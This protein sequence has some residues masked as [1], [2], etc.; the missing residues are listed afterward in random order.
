MHV[1]NI[2]TSNEKL[3]DISI[4]CL[5]AT[6]ILTLIRRYRN[7]KSHRRRPPSSHEL[8]IGDRESL[9]SNFMLLKAEQ[10][11]PSIGV[12]CAACGSKDE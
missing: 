12:L 10:L 3:Q 6:P 1:L 4:D 9:L 8:V 5:N 11:D 2:Y 7:S